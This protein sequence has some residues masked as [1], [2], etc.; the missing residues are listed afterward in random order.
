MLAEVS[1]F[2]QKINESSY[3]LSIIFTQNDLIITTGDPLHV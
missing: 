3:Y 1:L 2:C